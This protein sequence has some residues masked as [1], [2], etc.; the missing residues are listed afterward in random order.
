MLMV[1]AVRGTDSQS[2]I[3][4]DP[5]AEIYSC[6]SGA[7]SSFDFQANWSFSTQSAT[8]C[9][10]FLLGHWRHCDRHGHQGA[11]LRAMFDDLSSKD[12]AMLHDREVE[13]VT[14]PRKVERLWVECQRGSFAVSA[15]LSTFQRMSFWEKMPDLIQLCTE[16]LQR[17]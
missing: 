9:R 5:P 13:L 16:T 14:A 15:G 3:L 1:G 8:S 6:V 10:R 7:I 2:R 4:A 11:A 12:R 17:A